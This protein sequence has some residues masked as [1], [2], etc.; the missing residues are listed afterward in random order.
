MEKEGVLVLSQQ[1]DLKVFVVKVFHIMKSV[2]QHWEE[3]HEDLRALAHQE[4]W[5][6]VS[7]FPVVL[8][9]V[10]HYEGEAL[11]VL[12]V[13]YWLLAISWHINTIDLIENILNCFFRVQVRNRDNSDT[14]LLQELNM[15]PWYVWDFLLCGV[16]YCVTCFASSDLLLG[17]LGE[18][19]SQIKIFTSSL[20][21]VR[22]HWLCHHSINRSSFVR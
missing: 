21:N 5:E 9:Y 14:S 6:V 3:L 10:F 12:A 2:L 11:L 8:G 1:L 13:G 17:T 4:H 18:I 20:K 19:S 22:F 7:V 15:G 16:Q